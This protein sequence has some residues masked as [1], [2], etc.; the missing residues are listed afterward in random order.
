MA[1]SIESLVVWRLDYVTLMS[2][3][4]QPPGS[5]GYAKLQQDS[6]AGI[7]A[8]IRGV[9]AIPPS[10]LPAVKPLL[11]KVL[12][13]EAVSTVMQAMDTKVNLASNGS[14]SSVE[15]GQTNLQLDSM[16][17]Q[18]SW[19]V[20]ENPNALADDQLIW[21]AKVFAALGM[22]HASEKTYALGAASATHSHGLDPTQLYEHVQT[23]KASVRAI[24]HDQL[25]QGPKAYSASPA[26]LPADLYKQA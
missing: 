4:G 17:T 22:G 2:T 1:K 12:S 24:D 6:L 26:E 15:W 18:S 5:P 16:M 7:L 14:A 8:A 10:L 23:L 3:C 19:Q 21:M 9:K 11:D 25:I 20:F 13:P